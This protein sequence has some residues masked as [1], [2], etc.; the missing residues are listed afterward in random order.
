MAS[1]GEVGVFGRNKH[2]VFLKAMIAA[3]FEYP[4][5][6]VLLSIDDAEQTIA[7]IPWIRLLSKKL[8]LYA[9]SFTAAILR[10][11]GVACNIAQGPDNAHVE[12]NV[13]TLLKKRELSLVIQL[14]DK[15]H[16]FLLRRQREE[17]ASQDYKIR[18]LATDFN[19]P[20][21]TEIR[22]A[23]LMAEALDKYDVRD[24]EVLP[25]QSYVKSQVQVRK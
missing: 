24:M 8:V 23:E 21:I 1:T 20:L 13:M 12:P 22:L 16:D 2:E 14:R 5:R 7:F 25:Y 6:S 17:T 4:R 10:G 18:R 9:T 3:K 11:S 19:T 15:T